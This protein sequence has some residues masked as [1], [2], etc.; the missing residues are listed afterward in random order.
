[1]RSPG[2]SRARG[3]PHGASTARSRGLSLIHIYP[4]R[5]SYKP[6][7]VF[8]NGV[9]RTST[10][11]ITVAVEVFDEDLIV[12]PDGTERGSLQVKRTHG[13]G[14]TFHHSTIDI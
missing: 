9:E 8:V 6:R 4:A 10:A 2:V 13:G 1:M 14:G 5:I 3:R 11:R 7:R 12:L